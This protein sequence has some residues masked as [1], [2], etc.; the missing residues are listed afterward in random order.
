MSSSFELIA[1]HTQSGTSASIIKVRGQHRGLIEKLPVLYV[2]H[3]RADS[4][5]TGRYKLIAIVFPDIVNF[6]LGY[7]LLALQLGAAVDG[8]TGKGIYRIFNQAIHRKARHICIG[9]KRFRNGKAVGIKILYQQHWLI[10]GDIV[11]I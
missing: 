10:E 3:I 2:T 1:Q 7:I 11:H 9:H 6:G 4:C 5:P 8:L